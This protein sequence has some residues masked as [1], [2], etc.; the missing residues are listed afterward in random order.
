MYTNV[1]KQVL[2]S[3]ACKIPDKC[4]LN[5]TLKN[6][7]F[8]ACFVLKNICRKCRCKGLLRTIG[9]SHR[10]NRAAKSLLQEIKF[11]LENDKNDEKSYNIKF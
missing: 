8:S 6:H 3:L 10:A 2:E 4:S 7:K 1:K 11:T 5:P 9:V